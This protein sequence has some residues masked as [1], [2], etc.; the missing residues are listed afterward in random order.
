MTERG[1]IPVDGYHPVADDAME[2]VKDWCCEDPARLAMTIE[3]YA[4]CAIEGNPLAEICGDTLR[5]I[6]NGESVPDRYLLGLAWNLRYMEERHG[7]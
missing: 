1:T 2:W 7:D 4:S 5:R 6:T 3:S